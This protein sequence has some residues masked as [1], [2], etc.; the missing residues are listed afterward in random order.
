MLRGEAVHL[1]VCILA[2]GRVLVDGLRGGLLDLGHLTVKQCRERLG[3]FGHCR[4]EGGQKRIIKA[5]GTSLLVL[6]HR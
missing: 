3:E 1:L 6:G 2:D 5:A 4:K